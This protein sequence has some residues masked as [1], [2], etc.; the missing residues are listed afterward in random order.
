MSA[1]GN[2]YRQIYGKLCG[3]HPHLYP[4]HFQWLATK[5]LYGDLKKILPQQSGRILDV[6]CRDKPYAPWLKQAETHFGIDIS[7]GPQVDAIIAPNEPWPLVNSSFDVVICLQVLQYVA[8][9]N[10]LFNEIHRVLKPGGALIMTFP[11]AYNQHTV[12]KDYWRFSVDGMQELLAA[13]FKIIECKAQGGVGSTVGS[14]ILNWLEITMNQNKMARLLKGLLLPLWMIFCGII[15]VAGFLFDRIDST[16]V[17]YSN[18]L[19]VAQK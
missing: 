18:V 1:I 3:V 10:N 9:L 8:D 7:S 2:F 19:L 11:F 5:D 16:K 15:N 6:G 4:W 14:F 13:R 17:F 12:V